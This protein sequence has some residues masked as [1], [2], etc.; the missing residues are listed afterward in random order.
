[1]L[2]RQVKTRSRESHGGD[3][4]AEDVIDGLG[5]IVAR[6]RQP[7]AAELQESSDRPSTSV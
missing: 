5:E 3:P 1:M 2:G 6:R 4:A 7:N